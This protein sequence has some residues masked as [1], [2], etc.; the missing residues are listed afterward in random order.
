MS[1]RPSLTPSRAKRAFR[2]L[3]YR[4]PQPSSSLLGQAAFGHRAAARHV[5]QHF[6]E[7]RLIEQLVL[8]RQPLERVGAG[9]SE[10]V[11]EVPWALRRLPPGRPHVLDVGT[12]FASIAY[13]RLLLRLRGPTFEL[14]DAAPFDPRDVAA[15]E[16][17]GIRTHVADV[18]RLPFRD[19]S[20]DAVTC[21]ST[22]EHIGKDNDL[23]FEEDGG[24]DEAGDVAALCELRRV[25]KEGGRIVL[26]VPGGMRTDFGWY[27][28]Y[29][30][31]TFVGVAERAGLAVGEAEFFVRDADGWGPT[32]PEE[33][34]ERTREQ[35]GR[36]VGALICAVLVSR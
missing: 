30:V 26:T 8:N 35:G 7:E 13:K 6:A 36:T 23:Y 22:L 33:I 11:V 5:R 27:R 15:F 24:Y 25:T 3:R 32:S 12:A 19:A 20:F 17:A 31:P 34:H 10:R 4:L 2:S 14:V 21:V 16:A 28:Q 9:L 1:G 18:R 29:D